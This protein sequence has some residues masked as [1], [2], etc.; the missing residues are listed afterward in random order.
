MP[1]NDQSRPFFGRQFEL[2]RLKIFLE[3]EGSG[4]IDVRGRRRIGKSELLKKAATLNKNS[5][6]CFYFSGRED[7]NAQ[8]TLKRFV[9]TWDSTFGIKFLSEFKT[10]TISWDFIFEKI[11]ERHLANQTIVLLL[12]EIQW[13]SP[14]G[15]GFCGLIK[16]FWEN[17]H[18]TGNLKIV[19]SGSSNSFFHKYVDGDLATLR[20]LKTSASIWV[21]P[22][23]PSEV[24][25]YYFPKW[26][27]EE[28]ALLYMFVGGVPYYLENILHDKNFL[29]SM[30]RSFCTPNS[31]FL[32]EIDAVLKVET[33]R[34]AGLKNLK[35]VLGSLSQDGSTQAAI[36]VKTGLP[37]SQISLIIERALDWRLVVERYPDGPLKQNTAGVRYFMP[38]FYLNF[39]FQIIEPL[40]PRIRNN[41]NEGML[42]TDVI[43]TSNNG[44]FVQNFSGRSFE[45]LVAQLL[46]LG[47]SNLSQRSTPMFSAFSLKQISYEVSTYW[48]AGRTQ[49]DIVLSSKEDREV[50]IIECKW[51]SSK[52]GSTTNYVMDVVRK[53]F[54]NIP[55]QWHRSN[56]LM[57]SRQPSS[58]LVKE[59]KE[60]GVTVLTIDDLFE[61]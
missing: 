18:H 48:M 51:L 30:N 52:L 17:Q 28:I 7:E 46:E 55:K 49:I 2:S 14:Q 5:S 50:R 19:L 20:G 29:R 21:M 43:V 1:T 15:S 33:S 27:R 58:S 39:Y 41:L 32:E 24:Q 26:S 36:A 16:D 31:V 37:A 60:N 25:R 9:K 11:T 38:D 61:L 12:D 10:T 42:L 35:L 56:W 44:Y 8:A 22:F 3:K 45:M 4:F 57:L 59:A 6:S 23:S 53:N 54:P 13:I 34:V 40:S 47:K